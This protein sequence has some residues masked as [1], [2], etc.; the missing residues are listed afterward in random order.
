MARDYLGDNPEFYPWLRLRLTFSIL[1]YGRKPGYPTSPNGT[2]IE[3][4]NKDIA[5]NESI[6][7]R[8]IRG[9]ALP[10]GP[11]SR[12]APSSSW[13]NQRQ[14]RAAGNAGRF[15]GNLP[16]GRWRRCRVI[17]HPGPWD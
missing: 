17:G 11:Q 8:P 12:E 6:H 5:A 16:F 14:P 13:S 2:G 3:A 15:Q 1:G 4:G 9:F 7:D 10:R